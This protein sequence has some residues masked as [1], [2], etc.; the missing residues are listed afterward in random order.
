MFAYQASFTALQS[1]CYQSRALADAVVQKHQKLEAILPELRSFLDHRPCLLVFSYDVFR[2]DVNRAQQDYL[3]P[4]F[5]SVGECTAAF[6]SLSS[7]R[8]AWQNIAP[9]RAFHNFI[10][11]PMAAAICR[12]ESLVLDYFYSGRLRWFV[13]AVVSLLSKALSTPHNNL[14]LLFLVL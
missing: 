11:R 1:I 13:L 5:N 4:L 14:R 2:Y 8:E 3:S 12:C 9:K 7:N 6:Y 10:P